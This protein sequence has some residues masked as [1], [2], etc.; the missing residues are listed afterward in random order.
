MRLA[1]RALAAVFVTV[2]ALPLAAFAQEQS[3][4][5]FEAGNDNATINGTVIG[6]EYIDY[7]LGAQAGQS[8][9]VSLIPE[10]ATGMANVYFNILPPGSAGEAIYNGS[11]L[12]PDATGITLPA[13]GD[14]T[15]RVYQLG[16]DADDGRTT[17]FR[18]S[19]SIM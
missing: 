17:A 4:V 14:Y 6:D 18:I 1:R 5:S 19:V 2:A 11:I 7:L 16:D 9:S 3:R 10:E 15:I 12:G 8:M 13:D